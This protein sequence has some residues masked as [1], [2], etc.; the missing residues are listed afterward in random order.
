[1]K[2]SNIYI[3]LFF[4]LG[5]SPDQQ[6]YRFE[7][8]SQETSANCDQSCLNSC[9]SIFSL[10][11]EIDQC[12]QLTPEEVRLA[13]RTLQ[14]MKSGSWTAVSEEGLSLLTR[15]SYKPWIK[16]ARFNLESAEDMLL[17]LSEEKWAASYT[18]TEVLEEGLK[19]L[20]YLPGDRGVKDA[21]FKPIDSG[22]TF[23]E[24]MALEDNRVLFEKNHSLIQQV[25]RN[26]KLCIKDIYCRQTLSVVMD[27]A[28]QL[29][30]SEEPSC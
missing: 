29:S 16:Y 8:S 10:P 23:L 6:G 18:S 25:C 7:L 13:S 30:L 3:F 19:T 24:I 20:S 14:S 26:Q 15:I 21:L 4:V 1:M 9:K 2:I 17:W 27:K 11:E 5:C 28:K 12:T 22:K